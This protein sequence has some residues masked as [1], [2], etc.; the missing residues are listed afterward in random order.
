MVKPKNCTS[1]HRKCH[2]S[3]KS[4]IL[5]PIF[6]KFSYFKEQTID[7]SF[8]ISLLVLFKITV[9]TVVLSMILFSTNL[10]PKIQSIGQNTLR[11]LNLFNP[12]VRHQRGSNSPFL[13]QSRGQLATFLTTVY[14]LLSMNQLGPF[15]LNS[16]TIYKLESR[17]WNRWYI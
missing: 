12:I 7:F 1:H 15:I 16:N 9:D 14:F 3:D 11:F 2:W 6:C 5:K 4:G 8:K 17:N 10:L 13:K